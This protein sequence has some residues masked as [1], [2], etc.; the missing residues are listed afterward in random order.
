MSGPSITFDINPN[1]GV[2]I[3]RQ[4]IDQ[5][6]ALVAGGRLQEGDYLPSVRHVARAASVNPM[7][8]SKAYAQ[9]EGEGTVERVRGQGMRVA[10]PAV[11]GTLKQR[12][13][14]FAELLKPVLNRARQLGLNEAQ[15]RAIVDRLLEDLES[16]LNR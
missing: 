4:L 5:V 10:A 16:C 11:N 14:Q 7:T 8:V 9:L 2:P 12:Q 15:T 1:S 3:Y 13:T 6:H